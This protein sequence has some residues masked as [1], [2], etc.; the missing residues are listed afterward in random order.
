MYLTNKS[1]NYNEFHK[2]GCDF[3]SSIGY[4]GK[5]Y[6]TAY[7]WKD[8]LELDTNKQVNYLEIGAFHGGN[9]LTFLNLYGEHA[10]S[11]VH[12]IDPWLSYD[13]YEEYSQEQNTNYQTFMNNINRISSESLSKLY[14]HRGFSHEKLIHFTDIYF[15]VIYIDGNHNP[16]YV[17]E[18]AVI[19]FRKLKKNGYMIFDDYGW[20]NV[21]VGV[22]AF[23]KVYEKQ[24][25]IIACQNSQVIIRKKI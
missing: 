8:I 16:E 18:D 19:S 5:V 25:E 14:I 22:D 23:L 1:V 10:L 11:E 21:H 17:L 20:S 2:K 12:C 4:I 9:A 7:F 13:E 3:L 24:I 6:R 15:D